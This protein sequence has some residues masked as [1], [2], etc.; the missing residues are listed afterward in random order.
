MSMSMRMWGCEYDR[1]IERICEW[2]LEI[3]WLDRCVNDW[4]I[5]GMWEWVYEYENT[6][7]LSS[8]I[9]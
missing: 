1:M 8:K 4:M 3:V 2:E 6:I 9:E 5:G 7:K